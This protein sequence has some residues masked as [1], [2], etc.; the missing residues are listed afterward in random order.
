MYKCHNSA[1]AIAFLKNGKNH[2]FEKKLKICQKPLQTA[3]SLVEPDFGAIFS[4][5]FTFF[6]FYTSRKSVNPSKTTQLWLS[7]VN[8]SLFDK[9]DVIEKKR[10]LIGRGETWEISIGKE[11]RKEKKNK[12]EFLDK[13][14]F[15]FQWKT[16]SFLKAV[17]F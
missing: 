14:Q 8:F 10:P 16:G 15:Y 11:K 17:F 5:L 2:F 13:K 9:D 7:W 12:R 4:L 6:L 3:H 1:I